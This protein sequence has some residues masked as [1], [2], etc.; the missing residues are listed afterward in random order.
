[1]S[2]RPVTGISEELRRRAIPPSGGA[3]CLRYIGYTLGHCQPC[4]CAFVVSDVTSLSY[5]TSPAIGAAISPAPPDSRRG[6]TFGTGSP[7]FGQRSPLPYSRHNLAA[8]LD[9]GETPGA[10]VRLRYTI[11]A[12]HDQRKHVRRK[13]KKRQ[14]R[15]IGGRSSGVC[16]EVEF[17]GSCDPGELG[18]RFAREPHEGRGQEIG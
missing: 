10:S 16:R 2:R 14:S 5:L 15:E 6:R 4:I 9:H 17:I 3:P 1:M 7:L 18:R 12:R 11:N 8:C 13:R